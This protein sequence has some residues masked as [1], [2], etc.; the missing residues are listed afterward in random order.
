MP[1]ELLRHLAQQTLPLTV[2][3]AADID[4]LRVLRAAGH[5]AVLLPATQAQGETLFARVLTV[6]PAG[7][8]ALRTGTDASLPATADE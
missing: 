5:V 4:K 6:T 8:T 3:S 7:Y 2:T 1:L